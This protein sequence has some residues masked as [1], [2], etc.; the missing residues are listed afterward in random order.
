MKVLLVLPPCLFTRRE[1]CSIEL[2][3]YRIIPK[4]L[5][6]LLQKK[7]HGQ[8]LPGEK[9]TGKSFSLGLTQV[10]CNHDHQCCQ[11]VTELGK[12]IHGCSPVLLSTSLISGASGSR[13]S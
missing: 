8:S 12:V 3:A 6:L 2:S 1:E 11:F 7:E 10:T 13:I 4:M 9:G 5:S